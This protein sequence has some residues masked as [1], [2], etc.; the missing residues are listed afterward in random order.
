MDTPSWEDGTGNTCT[1]YGNDYC[2][3]GKFKT[4][5]EYLCGSAYNFPEKSC[6]SC[7]N[8]RGMCV[9]LFLSHSIIII[10]YC[11]TDEIDINWY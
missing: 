4:G 10:K 1:E 3:N 6:C 11:N 7:G 5:Y 2:E 8:G 9:E